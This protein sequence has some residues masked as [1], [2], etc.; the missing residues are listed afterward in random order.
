MQRRH[1]RPA[2]AGEPVPPRPRRQ[3]GARGRPA[4]RP[5]AG[6]A[7]APPRRRSTS[8]R[9]RTPTS[10]T[11]TSRVRWRWPAGTAPTTCCRPTSRSTSSG[12]ACA[13][14][15]SIGVGGARRPGDRDPRAH[16][17][18][19]GLPGPP[20]R[21]GRRPSRRA[22]QRRQPPA[23]HGRANRPRS[24]TPLTR[25]L[26]RAQWVSAR[27]ARRARPRDPA[28]PHPRLR[29][30]L[31]EQHRRA[32][33]TARP[34]SAT[35]VTTNPALLTE[36]DRFVDDLVA[37]FGPIPAYYEHM[38]P[39]NRA[40]AGRR[41]PLPA[42]PLTADE[43]RDAMADG[44]WVVD[45]RGRDRFAEAHLAGT[46]SVEYSPPVRDVRRVAGAVARPA[47]R[48]SPTA[49]PTSAPAL[50]DL[51][52]IGIDGVGTHVLDAD[53]AAA[54]DVPPHRLD[55]LPRRATRA[56][57]VRRRPAAR[58]VRGRPPARRRPRARAR[59]R[60][61]PG[62]AAARASCGCTAAP[63]TAPASPPACCTGPAARWCT[64]TTTGAGSTELAIPTTTGG[65]AA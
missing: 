2:R 22:V 49:C 16:P 10:T 50:R 61:A 36:Q 43:V 62:H 3:L 33:A 15:T 60:A 14:A 8:W 40:G 18:P 39:L 41:P 46:V 48:C 7:G 54:G 31:R 52:G 64:S 21:P 30:L 29:Q 12:S 37:G 44:A 19:P 4:A 28:A 26:A 34:P 51:A 23:R 38:G 53:P 24:A 20:P 63:A 27:S 25:D 35:S 13:T 42:Q 47:G 17:A 9:W 57:V 6:R 11:T 1:D 65:L 56:G 58:R 32:R 55:R 59:G 5:G 45:L